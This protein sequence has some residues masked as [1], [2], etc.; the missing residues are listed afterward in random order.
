[1]SQQETGISAPARRNVGDFDPLAAL[2]DL[3]ADVGLSTAG[4]GGTVSFSG[5]DPILPAAHRL[6]TCIGIPIMANAVAAVARPTRVGSS[7]VDFAR[8][9]SRAG[10]IRCEC[11]RAGGCRWRIA[12]PELAVTAAGP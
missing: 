5:Q 10:R 6:G 11:A 9:G 8:P 2:D 7:S 4:T 12:I 1:M 3:L